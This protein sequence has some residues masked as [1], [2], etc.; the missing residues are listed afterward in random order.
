MPVI[1]CTPKVLLFAS[2]VRI[3]TCIS[4]W[5]GTDESTLRWQFLR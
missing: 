2:I 5:M 4:P 1:R 3:S